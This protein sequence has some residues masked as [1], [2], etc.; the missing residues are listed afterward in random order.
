MITDE[1]FFSTLYTLQNILD[2][3]VLSTLY[4][5]FCCQIYLR[6]SFQPLMYKLTRYTGWGDRYADGNGLRRCTDTYTYAYT[7]RI[8][9]I[10]SIDRF[11]SVHDFRRGCRDTA[12]LDLPAPACLY[13][14][15]ITFF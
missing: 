13:R 9:C 4:I 5:L 8:G 7:G 12:K 10:N 3:E 1:L 14:F 11:S 6:V 2:I 15:S